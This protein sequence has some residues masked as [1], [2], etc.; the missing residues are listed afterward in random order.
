MEET[1]T[2]NAYKTI[3]EIWTFNNQMDNITISRNFVLKETSP[4][5]AD[6]LNLNTFHNLES[7]AI[8]KIDEEEEKYFMEL[9]QEEKRLNDLEKKK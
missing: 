6:S 3:S 2:K 4:K 7:V 1:I 8:K 9:E 5:I